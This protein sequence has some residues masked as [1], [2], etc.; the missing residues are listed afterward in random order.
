MFNGRLVASYDFP[1]FV[2]DK[3]TK[4][5][6]FV[7]W[8]DDRRW[9]ETIRHAS[10]EV[11]NGGQR[12]LLVA[13]GDDKRLPSA[14]WGGQ[15]G[16]EE[17]L[18]VMVAGDGGGWAAEGGEGDRKIDSYFFNGMIKLY[19]KGKNPFVMYCWT[20]LVMEVEY[21]LNMCLWDRKN[22]EYKNRKM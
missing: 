6:G 14:A 1:I 13:K 15:V 17:S 5:L 7:K 21:L 4:K 18:Q 2:K 16:S 12:K 22:F 19:R 3:Q 9:G 8:G 20:F 11:P 10:F